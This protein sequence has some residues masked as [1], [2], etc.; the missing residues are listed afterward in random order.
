[1]MRRPYLLWMALLSAG[2]PALASTRVAQ[3][4]FET[5]HEMPATILPALRW[6]VP[7]LDLTLF[8]LALALVA[9]AVHRVRRRG[10]ILGVMLCCLAYFGFARKGCVCAVGAI[11]N[12][13]YGLSVGGGVPW[14]V[15]AFFALPLILSL[16]FGRVFC[17]AVCPLGAI[18]DLFVWPRS[19]RLPLWLQSALGI[20]PHVVLAV[21]VTAAAGGVFLVCRY[22]PFVGFFR[23]SGPVAM[24]LAGGVLLAFSVVVARPYCRF[25]CPYGVLLRWT[26]RWSWRRVS[27]TPGECVRCGLCLDSC[28]FGAIRAPTASGAPDES[29]RI[30]RRRLVG[31]LCLA[32]LLLLAG[33]WGGR[34]LAARGAAQ[35]RAPRL[36]AA[37][38]VAAQTGERSEAVE[39]FELSRGDVQQMQAASLRVQRRVVW[40][41]TL[42]GVYVGGVL[43]VTLIRVSVY[44]R[45]EV[46]TAD[47]SLCLACGRCYA[48]CPVQRE[49]WGMC[50]GG[51]SGGGKSG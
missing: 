23:R 36:E 29:R 7:A 8:V 26:S 51:K 3:P 32:P 42:A 41:G 38:S 47:P 35:L 13:V 2:V 39:A 1:M 20:L 4:E 28:P 31:L 40:W 17:A 9:W 48:T 50:G 44:R 45:R 10:V 27:P 46:Y 34:H 43:V 25:V 15:V 21:G 30:G 18:Q 19:R 6:Y 33:G 24:L 12:V 14:L 16:W 5:A 22:D 11:Q 49:T 37:V